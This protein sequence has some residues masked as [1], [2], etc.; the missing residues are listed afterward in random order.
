L[1]CGKALVYLDTNRDLTC[2]YC[3]KQASANARCTLGHFVCDACH[4][5]SA[6]D[7][8]KQVCLKSGEADALALMQHIRSHPSFPVHGPEHHA[9]VPAVILTALRNSGTSVTDEQILTAIERGRT[10][11]G[12]ACAF[13]G[14]CGA[15][16]GAGIAISL[17]IGATPLDGKKRQFIQQV[18]RS[19][20]DEIAAYDA[21]RCCQRDAW[22]AIRALSKLLADKMEITL[23]ATA[24]IACSQFREN[25]ECIRRQ[26]PLWPSKTGGDEK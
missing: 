11:A 22:L 13:F 26:C 2:H 10:I 18:T 17:V 20:L 23:K 4:S 19:V 25:R 5:A 9:M 8:L 7:V 6:V 16:L 3:G 21:A 24:P 15:A 12:G 1:V 14:A